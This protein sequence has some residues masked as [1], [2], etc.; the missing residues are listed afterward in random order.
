MRMTLVLVCEFSFGLFTFSGLYNFILTI[1]FPSRFGGPTYGF[2]SGRR[3]LT[4]YTSPHT[5]L[6]RSLPSAWKCAPPRLQYTTYPREAQT[7]RS[8]SRSHHD[9][10]SARASV[11]CQLV[12]RVWVTATR[13]LRAAGTWVDRSHRLCL[14]HAQGR[15]ARSGR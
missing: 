5:T 12:E 4:Q 14:D 10:I 6:P 2:K 9:L 15:R 11:E 8:S 1:P 3:S 13:T 7:A